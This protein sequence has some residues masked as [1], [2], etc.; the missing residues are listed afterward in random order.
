MHFQDNPDPETAFGDWLARYKDERL[1]GS[2]VY[3]FLSEDHLRDAF[4][5]GV[6]A[7]CQAG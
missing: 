2:V 1:D 7:G 4:M 6:L 5:A 3:H